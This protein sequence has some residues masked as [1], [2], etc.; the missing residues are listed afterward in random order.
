MICLTVKGGHNMKEEDN[1]LK[2][3]GNRNPFTVPENY[4]EDFKSNLMKQLPEKE[5]LPSAK[6]ISLWERVKPWVYMAAMFCGLMFGARILIG[7]PNT[8]NSRS[9]LTS[10]SEEMQL[11]KQLQLIMDNTMMDDYELYSFLMEDD[12]KY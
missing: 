12:T 7:N 9:A 10:E 3:Y 8:E 1:L 6:E 2:K 11:D 5:P 4:F